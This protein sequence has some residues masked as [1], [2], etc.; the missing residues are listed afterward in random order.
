MMF[1]VTFSY[2][3]NI[4]KTYEIESSSREALIMRL[5]D[6]VGGFIKVEAQIPGET[7]LINLAMVSGIRIR[8]YEG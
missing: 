5:H 8:D 6:N 7:E 1:T 4:N 2:L 3:D